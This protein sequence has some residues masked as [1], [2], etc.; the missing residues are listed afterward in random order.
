M[1]RK[2]EVGAK[3]NGHI[4]LVN[5]DNLPT[6]DKQTWTTDRR[7]RF[8]P[9]VPL[10]LDQRRVAE[11]RHVA[12]FA[13]GGADRRDTKVYTSNRSLRFAVKRVKP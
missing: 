8:A 9:I 13:P 1:R 6:R 12:R 7:Q 2:H 10:T 3:G 11:A 4:W 5:M